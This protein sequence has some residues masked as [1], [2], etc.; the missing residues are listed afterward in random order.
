MVA[1][2]IDCL[3]WFPVGECG[4]GGGGLVGSMVGWLA[5]LTTPRMNSPLHWIHGWMNEWMVARCG[6][7]QID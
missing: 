1:P 7:K 5:V 3:I 2:S 6:D 4:R